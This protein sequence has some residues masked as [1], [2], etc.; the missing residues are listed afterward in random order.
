M[1]EQDRSKKSGES[2]SDDPMLSWIWA[3]ASL[4]GAISTESVDDNFR[5]WATLIYDKEDRG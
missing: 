3:V 4:R 5:K 1:Q 2:L